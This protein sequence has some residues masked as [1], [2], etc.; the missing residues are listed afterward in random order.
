[1]EIVEQPDSD[2]IVEDDFGGRY[3]IIS[4][5]DFRRTAVFLEMLKRAQRLGVEL[6]VK[7]EVRRH[8]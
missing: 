2:G 1:M 3:L 6:W 8:D 5:R 4:E 7:R